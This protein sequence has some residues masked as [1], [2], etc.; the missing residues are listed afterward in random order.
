MQ[1]LRFIPLDSSQNTSLSLRLCEQESCEA[2]GEFRAPKSSQN[3]QEYYWF[4]LDHVR[5]YN[6]AWDFYKGMTLKEIEASRVS[7]I[8]WNRPS[9]PVG[10]WRALLENAKC[11]DGTDSFLKEAPSSLALPHKVQ[12]AMRVLALTLPLTLEALKK[13]YKKLVKRHH[14]DLNPNNQQAEEQLKI[15]NEAY[16]IVKK[17]LG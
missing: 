10:T 1:K 17:Y 14:P 2:M 5:E 12:K 13:Q 4:C 15:I 16:Q 3:L 7:D 6:K 9:W 11:F 8:T